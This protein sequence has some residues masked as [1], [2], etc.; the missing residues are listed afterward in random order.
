[1]V[2]SATGTAWVTDAFNQLLDFNRRLGSHFR[3]PEGYRKVDQSTNRTDGQRG[4]TQH[5]VLSGIRQVVGSR[6]EE[7]ALVDEDVDQCEDQTGQH[8][9]GCAYV[10]HALGENTHHQCGEQGSRSYTEGQCHNLGR[11]AWRV[12]A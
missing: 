2:L 1:V 5:P 6:N 4:N 3:Y 11:K 12:G 10:V 8:T 9:Q 7:P